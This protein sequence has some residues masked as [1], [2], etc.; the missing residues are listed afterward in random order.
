MPVF[1]IHFLSM[2]LVVF[3]IHRKTFY[4]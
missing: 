2:A 1:F 4:L 3:L